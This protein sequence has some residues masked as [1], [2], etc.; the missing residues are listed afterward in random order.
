[1]FVPLHRAPAHG[2][3]VQWADGKRG[4]RRNDGQAAATDTW[5][6]LARR[7]PPGIVQAGLRAGEW[8]AVTACLERRL[9]VL[10][11]VAFAVRDLAYRCGGSAGLAVY[12]HTTH[13]LPVSS[14]GATHRRDTW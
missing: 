9:P 12:S 8:H 7:E 6:G 4:G 14:L 5:F 2:S 10:R 13:R 3:W 1:M 11:T